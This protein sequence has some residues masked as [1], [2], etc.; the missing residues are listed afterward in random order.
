MV[1]ID[2]RSYFTSQKNKKKK[3]QTG[4]A[5][6]VKVAG[7]VTAVDASAVNAEPQSFSRKKRKKR[8]FIEY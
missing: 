5:E 3:S 1:I 7:N 4:I 8:I 6:L 2:L